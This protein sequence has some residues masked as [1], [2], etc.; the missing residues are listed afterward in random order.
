M[1]HDPP[2]PIN[3]AHVELLKQIFSEFKVSDK[4]ALLWMLLL[5]TFS[6]C[7]ESGVVIDEAGAE[8]A[9]LNP[10]TQRD[11]AMV[12]AQLWPDRSD[13]VRTSYDY[14]YRRFT[15]DIAAETLDALAIEYRNKVEELKKQL[16]VD[17]RI[18]HLI[19]E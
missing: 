14:W 3:V 15:E 4:D 16:L 8:V 19:E 1:K 13:Q 2:V 7:V 11:A 18:A 5:H 10:L 6:I 17:S 9:K 12:I